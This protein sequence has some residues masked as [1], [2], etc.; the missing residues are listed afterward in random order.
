[1]INGSFSIFKKFSL[2]L[3][4]TATLFV[5]ATEETQNKSTTSATTSTEPLSSNITQQGP[6]K[7]SI[8][9][10]L[11]FPQEVITEFQ[12]IGHA[13]IDQLLSIFNSIG[14][15]LQNNLFKNVENPDK[16]RQELMALQKSLEEF[17]NHASMHV[18]KFQLMILGR[19]V[20]EFTRVLIEALKTK[21]TAI[22]AID[23]NNILKRDGLISLEG[24]HALLEK[25]QI[26]LNTLE[27]LTIDAP[28][29]WYNHATRAATNFWK[30]Y[31]LGPISERLV[32]YSGMAL[33]TI[34]LFPKERLQAD[35]LPKRISHVLCSVKDVI[36]GRQGQAKISLEQQ[37]IPVNLIKDAEGK[38]V[39]ALPV[40][41]VFLDNETKLPINPHAIPED[42]AI[43]NTS[44]EAQKYIKSTAVTMTREHGV[45]PS[46]DKGYLT[47]FIDHVEPVFLLGGEAY[48][49]FAVSK[50]F[51]EYAYKD[52]IS[53]KDATV[54][55][56]KVLHDKLEGRKSAKKS[57]D[58]KSDTNFDSI[59]GRDHIKQRF[60]PLID[61]IVHPE[62][63]TRAGIKLP[64]GFLL[65]G[66]PQTGKTFMVECLAGEIAR[67]LE[68]Q[69]KTDKLRVYTVTVHEILEK[70]ISYW[71]QLAR[72][73]APCII[74]I[75]EFDNLRAQ[76]DSNAT[77]LA[78][79]LQVLHESILSDERTPVFVI[80]A[81]NRPEN[82]DYALRQP[83]RFGEIIYFPFPLQ[84]DREIYFN[85]YFKK[86]AMDTSKFN[87]DMLIRSTEGCSYGVMQVTAN[88]VLTY[89]KESHEPVTQKHITQ[90]VNDAVKQIVKFDQEIP[91]STKRIIATRF[92]A[93]ALVSLLL[94]PD[95]KL[96]SI[97]IE[98]VIKDVGET[99]VAQRFWSEENGN[100]Q[101]KPIEFGGI[102][103][104][105][106]QDMLD[107][108]STNEELKQCKIALAG[109]VGQQ[110]LAM[111][112]VNHTQDLTIAVELAKKILFR[113]QNPQSVSRYERELKIGQSYKLVELCEKEVLDLLTA[114]KDTLAAIVEALLK[115]SSLSAEE[116]LEIEALEPVKDTSKELINKALTFVPKI[117][118]N[119]HDSYSTSIA[120]G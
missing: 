13:Q 39:N 17:K 99:H 44:K 109:N 47:R 70:T 110:V 25:N 116:I 81:T 105:Y 85:H 68:R 94:N 97:T 114:H 7:N 9:T 95:Q 5:H 76:R 1:M 100:K 88:K 71:V 66:P 82:I 28:L 46:D 10:Q 8:A 19:I 93:K 108:I 2:S 37:A 61:Y 43:F 53:L 12:D 86:R 115:C 42:A 22:P 67:Q 14:Q 48:G 29:T 57:Y 21:L 40:S 38:I 11:A 45:H 101:Q 98:Q 77:L 120:I 51:A 102:F 24:M 35:F 62:R 103:S 52:L 36:G 26:L 27:K 74:F 118:L 113:G 31:K 69:G 80:A 59:L 32:V 50:F 106:T 104:Y 16:T 20:Q 92:A 87:V 55:T 90:A 117:D 91:E 84:K 73:A 107:M 79:C 89:A 33:W 23:P 63:Y 75:D 18:D 41:P 30:K 6:A 78:E 72:Q 4:L 119:G 3:L 56:L 111:N 15:A 54:K 65:A 60:A 49:A 64:C 83:G 112:F 34:F 96:C 58:A